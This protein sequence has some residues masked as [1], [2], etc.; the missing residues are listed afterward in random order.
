M[1]A[2]T[3]AVAENAA[4]GIVTIRP[5][6]AITKALPLFAERYPKESITCFAR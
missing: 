3:I 4:P 6:S 2:I 5:T 1:A